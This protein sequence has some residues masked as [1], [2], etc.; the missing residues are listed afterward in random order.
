MISRIGLLIGLFALMLAQGCAPAEEPK[1]KTG[2]KP[3]PVP[4]RPAG[5]KN[6]GAN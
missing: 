3:I 5:P 2:G 1:L 4:G 6:V